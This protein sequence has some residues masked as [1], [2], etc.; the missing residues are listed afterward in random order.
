MLA[1]LLVLSVLQFSPADAPRLDAQE[2]RALSLL[3][4]VAAASSGYRL[5]SHEHDPG[6]GVSPR[7][8]PFSFWRA[9]GQ[10]SAG[11]GA[12]L[13]VG[14]AMWAVETL[15]LFGTAAFDSTYNGGAGTR[16]ILGSGIQTMIILNGAVLPFLSALPIWLISKIDRGY[17]HSF[18]WT[19][20]SGVA[21]Y[22]AYWAVWAAQP[23]RYDGLELVLWPT[24]VGSWL[25]VSLVQA[26][27]VHLTREPDPSAFEAT[28][29][30]AALVNVNGSRVSVGAP[31]PTL[32][33]DASRPGRMVPVFSLAQGRF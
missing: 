14:S 17:L 21:T 13:L 6:V 7:S 23:L 20:L 1:T 32:T 24:H 18:P 33:A 3:A 10:F 9:F 26:I 27:V 29:V 8:S 12:Q 31:L 4:P 22:A 2:T 11:F 30:T 15:A 16:T 28:S 5:L 25:L 19:W